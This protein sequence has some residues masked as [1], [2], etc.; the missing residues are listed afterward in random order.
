[1]LQ[2]SRGLLYV[3]QLIKHLGEKEDGLVVT[4]LS[5]EHRI[6][7]EIRELGDPSWRN[8]GEAKLTSLKLNQC[9]VLFPQPQK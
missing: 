6:C 5:T 9:F 8:L 7:S 3:K 2:E 1:M 4:Y